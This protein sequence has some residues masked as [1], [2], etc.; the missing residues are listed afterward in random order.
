M[1]KVIFMV[2]DVSEYKRALDDLRLAASVFTHAREGI[3][4]TDGSGKILAVNETF[5]H[6]TGYHRSEALGQNPRI[7]KSGRHSPEFYEA[8]WKVIL[9]MGHWTG[10]VWNRRKNGDE[11]AEMLTISAV[12]DEANKPQN[13]VSLFTDITPMKEYQSQLE[14]IAHY[15][16]LTGLA[17]RVL[18]ADRLRQAVV[19]S[20]RRKRV[21]SVVYLDLDGFK[22][23]NDMYGHAVGDELL[24]VLAQRMKLALRDIDS[25]ARLG[26]DEFVAVL[27]DLEAPEDCEPVLRRLLIS[28]SEPIMVQSAAGAV[29]VHVSASIG[30]A[31]YPRDGVDADLLMRHADQAMYLAKQAGKN[32]YHLFDAASDAA[33]QIQRESLDR[34]HRA[35]QER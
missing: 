18:F 27:V 19:Q 11:Y 4:I 33:V 25:L 32:C 12:L 29:V 30:A 22:A 14:R 31:I 1:T 15:D 3:M 21:L 13:Y 7:L 16:A 9:E 10:E 23:V 6:I 8:M 28:A 35:L 17:N 26:G 20:Q 2:R 24:I 5:T 34:I